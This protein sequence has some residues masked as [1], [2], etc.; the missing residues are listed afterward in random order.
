MQELGPKPIKP[1]YLA[2]RSGE[3]ATG[4][5]KKGSPVLLTCSPNRE[6]PRREE[7]QAYR[8]SK[9][10]IRLRNEKGPEPRGWGTWERE[11]DGPGSLNGHSPG[12]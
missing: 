1:R 11:G 2:A 3:S 10:G 8:V 6:P 4:E 7:T 9:I 5:G 12:S